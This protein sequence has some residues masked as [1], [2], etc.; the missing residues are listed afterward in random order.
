[1]LKLLIVNV[2]LQLSFRMPYLL[3]ILS[4]VFKGKK[5]MLSGICFECSGCIYDLLF[6]RGKLFNEKKRKA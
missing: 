2:M 5:K 4:K 6:Q 1:M 3:E